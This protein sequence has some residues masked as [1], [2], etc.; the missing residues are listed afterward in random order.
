MSLTCK[1]IVSC[2]E[3]APES[4]TRSAEYI[5]LPRLCMVCLVTMLAVVT[6][7]M[8]QA[9]FMD[10]ARSFALDSKD[11]ALSFSFT[12]TGYALAFLLAGPLADAFHPARLTA[13]GLALIAA[14]LLCASMTGSFPVFLGCMAI[15]GGAAALIPAAMFPY[16][17][18]LSPQHRQGLYIGAIVASATMGIIV[19]RAALGLGTQV[20]G[21]EV[22]YRLFAGLLALLA[23]CSLRVLR[24]PGDWRIAPA[25]LS[26]LYG[27][28]LRVLLHTQSVALLLAGFSLFF[29]FLGAITFLT[30]RLTAPPFDFTSGQ[31]GWISFAGLA[32]IIAPFSG[33]L[34]QRFGVFRVILPGLLCCL[35]ALQALGWS[36]SVPGT[37]LGIALLFLGVYA[38]QPLLFLLMGRGLP[39]DS[40]GSASSLYILCCIGGGSISS[41]L[42]RGVW[43]SLGWQGV[44]MACSAAIL[45]T[46]AIVCSL[47]LRSR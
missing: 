22:S 38:C 8:N 47:A 43:E 33:G 15:A 18:R 5:T 46:L 20:L 12:S 37:T 26:T 44:I 7:F 34:S 30:F 11:A 35:L 21:W 17:T 28:M 39:A 13:L 41:V 19:G 36:M 2:I 40:L 3:S 10:L 23:L 1:A 45:V 24:T 14:L 29:G 27:N 25:D 31:V 32:A 9:I 42:L 16:A 6:V 4:V